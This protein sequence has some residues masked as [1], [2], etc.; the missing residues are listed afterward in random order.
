MNQPRIPRIVVAYSGG[1][2]TSVIVKWLLEHRADE[3]VAFC[4]DVGQGEDLEA[5]RDKA[6]KTGATS[7][8][9]QDLREEFVR[10]FVLPCVKAHAVYEGQYLLGT[11]IARPII[12]RGLVEVARETGAIAICHGATG[13]GN[14]QVRFEQT[15]YALEPDIRIVAPWREWTFEGRSDLVAYAEQHEIPIEVTAEKPYSIDQNLLH[16]SYEG[17][18]LEDPWAAP[19]RDMFR[20][21]RDPES[22]PDAPREVL[23]DFEAGVP[24]AVDGQALGP[25]ALLERLNVIAGEHGVGRV[26]VVE[27]RSVGL[28]SRGVYETP[29]GTLLHLA[30]R[31][32]ESL[33][34]D[35]EQM[36]LLDDLAPRFAGLVY[37]GL[38]YAPE[39]E[40]LTALVDE[41]Q[42][43]TTG[44]ARLKLYK[45]SVIVTGR[46]AERSL[47]D[48][49]LASFEADQGAYRQADAEGFIKLRSLR[50]RT[51]AYRDRSSDGR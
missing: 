27:N 32:V 42:K 15:A 39:R 10:D 35:R 4:A 44:T 19:P 29:G 45:G 6:L 23:I 34:L 13:K 31:A 2:D 26:D 30:L 11:A 16:T 20:R 50:L 37:D 5:V 9:V 25:V 40:A 17:G 47:Y 14:D 46:R 43:H 22:A 36:R 51:R 8:V 38:W 41:V 7:C 3:V 1:L 18:V 12:A 48:A 28:K 49:R 21:T 24:V 33:T